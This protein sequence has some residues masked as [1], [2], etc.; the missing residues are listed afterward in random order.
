MLCGRR[1]CTTG[2]IRPHLQTDESRATKRNTTGFL[3]RTEPDHIQRMRSSLHPSGIALP[4]FQTG[5]QPDVVIMVRKNLL[6][7]KK[8]GF[9]RHPQKSGKTQGENSP[10]AEATA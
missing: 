5:L 2:A 7:R 10:T 1:R 3:N 9:F 4:G 6:G 8:A